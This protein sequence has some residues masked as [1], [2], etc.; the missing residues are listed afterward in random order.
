MKTAL[1]VIDMQMEMTHRTLSGRDRV[2]PEAEALVADLLSLFRERG[3]PV[4]HVHHNE[5]GSRVAFGRPGGEVMPCALPA[6]GETVLVKSASSAFTGTG[7]DQHLRAHGI[8]RLVIIGAVA[9]FCV[10][11]T[12]RWASDLGYAVILPGDALIGF[13]IARAD[14]SRIPAETVLDVTLSLLGSDF[15]RVLPAAKVATAL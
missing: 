14:G 13:D 9:A 6:E 11:S 15:A 3:L 10:T 7:L 12:V 8:D 2:N 1:L 4:I 5:P